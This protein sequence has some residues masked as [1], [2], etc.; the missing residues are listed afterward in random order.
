MTDKNASRAVSA[1]LLAVLMAACSSEAPE[2]ALKREIAEMHDAV[3]HKDP[4]GFLRYVTEDFKGEGGAMDKRSLRGVL[5]AQLMGHDKIAVTMG[6]P[7]IAITG[8]RA[9]VKVSALVVGGKWLPT[10]GR[11]LEIESGWQLEGGEWK[12]Y[13]AT[14]K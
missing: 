14:W 4:G 3:E 7:D 10:E 9:T 11:T 13:S 5:A 1:A 6:P 8:D 12:C 2:A